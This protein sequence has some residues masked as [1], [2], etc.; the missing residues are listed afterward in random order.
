MSDFAQVFSLAEDRSVDL[1]SVEQELRR[2]WMGSSETRDDQDAP[3]TR[4]CTL[5]LIA[6]APDSRS[7]TRASEVGTSITSRYPCR[8]IVGSIDEGSPDA[9]DASISAYC[10]PISASAKPI[11]CERITLYASG[12]RA[13]DLPW[14]ITPLLAPDVPV[15]VWLQGDPDLGRDLYQRLIALADRLVVDL[16]SANRPER[17]LPAMCKY[18]S[19]NRPA[20]TDMAWRR[21]AP[22]RELIATLFDPPSF[23]SLLSDIATVEIGYVPGGSGWP[24]AQ[25]ALVAA[26][27]CDRLNWNAKGKFGKDGDTWTLKVT[28]PTGPGQITLKPDTRP[29]YAPGKLVSIMLQTRKKDSQ[30]TVERSKRL[31]T[32]DLRIERAG[33]EPLVWTQPL[34]S[35]DSVW[36]LGQELERPHGSLAF[37]RVEFLLTGLV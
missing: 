18:I 15:F 24:Q 28:T 13:K 29:G 2:L 4:V 20:V 23:R 16:Q 33:A 7:A 30:F 25:P 32:A 10:H 22:W 9:L 34:R 3:V 17:L 31:D 27:L 11:F 37:E 19:A 6:I 36:I 35:P 26:W 14:A 1:R 5:N 21:T 12:K 8:V